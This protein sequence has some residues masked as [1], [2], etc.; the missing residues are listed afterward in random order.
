MKRVLLAWSVTW[1]AGCGLVA[2]LKDLPLPPDAASTQDAPGDD[3]SSSDV[4]LGDDQSA[5]DA[6]DAACTC[7]SI[8]Q[9]WTGPRALYEG[10][11][12][13]PA[14]TCGGEYGAKSFTGNS[15]LVAPPASCTSCTC[16]SQTGAK[17]GAHLSYYTNPCGS[18]STGC[19]AEDFA[20][21]AGACQG[22]GTGNGGCAGRYVQAFQADGLEQATGS[23]PPSGGAPNGA[24]PS[25]NTTAVAC[26]PLSAPPPGACD[27]GQVCAPA[28]S[29][30]FKHLC[31]FASGA[32]SCPM[33]SP[34]ATPYVFYTAFDDARACGAC[35]C[36]VPQNVCS[37]SGT[38]TFWTAFTCTGASTGTININNVNASGCLTL[39][40]MSYYSTW[41]PSSF[42]LGACPA[43]GG[44]PTGTVT[45]NANTATT[46]CCTQ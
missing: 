43:S 13:T 11:S 17:C 5:G 10:P 46:F 44:G 22:L 31:I 24:A 30:P 35:S 38:V 45:P 14:P 27:A 20:L 2:G 18:T 29:S 3:G 26:A 34:F 25:W 1:L 37:A 33:G 42:V 6:I 12:G 19:G 41:A 4:T 28:P 36:G 9:G 16:G 32:Q 23:C 39:P 21:N 15:D 7:V 40:M 8:P